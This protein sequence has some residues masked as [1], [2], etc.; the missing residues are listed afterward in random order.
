MILPPIFILP[1]RI[2]LLLINFGRA[3]VFWSFL[4]TMRERLSMDGWGNGEGKA[5]NFH[6]KL[7]IT[8]QVDECKVPSHSLLGRLI[9]IQKLSSL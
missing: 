3:V 7:I 4:Y 1:P 5:R 2:I 8:F 6:Q 9:G